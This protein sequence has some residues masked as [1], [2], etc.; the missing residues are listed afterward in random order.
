VKPRIVFFLL[1][2]LLFL[3]DAS[4]CSAANPVQVKSDSVLRPDAEL[5]FQLVKGYLIQIEGKI[6]AQNHLRFL[7]DTGA[8]RSIVDSRIADG[9]KLDSRTT[10]SFNFDRTLTWR[11]ATLT[12]VSFGPMRAANVVMLV[13]NLATYSK[14]NRKVD[15]IIGTDLLKSSSFTLDFNAK[16]VVFHTFN[17][18][19]P[20]ATIDPLS[21]CIFLEILVHGHP[22]R[23]IVD[24]GF[25]GILLF[26]ERLITAVPNLDIPQRSINVTV[27][28]KLHAK[29]TMFRD[30][31]I[32]PIRRNVTVLL[33]K[34]PAADVLPGVVGVAGIRALNAH[35]VNFNFFEGTVSWE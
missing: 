21:S 23:L 1:S 11:Q 19:I 12:E 35:R 17:E 31:A 20:A 14:F 34:S 8:S 13:G 5:P 6:G 28:E 7:L 30:I 3:A 4:P 33:V 18:P 27:G 32:G 15:A 16:K 2:H 29:Q 10:Q 24:T 22:I 25:D 9:L 26:E